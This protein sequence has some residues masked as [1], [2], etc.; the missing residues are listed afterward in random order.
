MKLVTAFIA[1]VQG[2]LADRRDGARIMPII[3]TPTKDEI[4]EHRR[5]NPPFK[6]RKKERKA[7]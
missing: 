7:K 2:M 1:A 5:N 3:H 4:A 6:R